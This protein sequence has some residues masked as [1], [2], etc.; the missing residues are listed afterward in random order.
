L[1]L[2]GYL[3]EVVTLHVFEDGGRHSVL[4]WVSLQ[5]LRW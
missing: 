3:I 1:V 2:L 4:L 5:C